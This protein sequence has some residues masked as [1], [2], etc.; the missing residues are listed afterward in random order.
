[1]SRGI[2]F[3]PSDVVLHVPPLTDTMKKTESEH[4]AALMVRVCQVRGD[5]WQEV[6]WAA[7]K[8]VIRADVAAETE[9]VASLMR[10][11]FFRP[12]VDRLASDGYVTTTGEP[13][14]IESL[15]FTEKGL[16]AIS[17]YVPLADGMVS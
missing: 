10:N 17:Q 7:V 4:A 11:P 8:E 5:M 1:M 12:M 9:P 2:S 6:P 3:K 14:K 13:G 15:K 16:R